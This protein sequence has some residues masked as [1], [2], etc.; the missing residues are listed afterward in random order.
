MPIYTDCYCLVDSRTVETCL[1]FLDEF[2]P[3]RIESADEYPLPLH[4]DHP[5][6]VLGD[7]HLVMKHLEEEKEEAYVLYWRS[8]KDDSRVKH[9]M[10]FYTNDGHLIV[11][12]SIEGE[13]LEDREAIQML[14]DLKAHFTSHI[15]CMRVEGP[16]PPFNASAFIAF[17]NA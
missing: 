8:T 1:R 3:E 10:L 17:C 13:S 12:V 7:V 11:G 5:Q 16:P 14:Q 6:K 15:G 2:L 9:G 4:S